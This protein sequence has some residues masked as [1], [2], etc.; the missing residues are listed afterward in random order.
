MA[1]K[2]SKEVRSNIMSKIRSKNTTPELK[3][4]EALKG[5]RL[6]YQPKMDGKPDFA[7][8]KKK[9]AVFVD[10]CF[11]HKCPKCYRPPK[12]NKKYWI[13]KIERNVERD[14]QIT[15]E[16]EELGWTAMRFWEHEVLESSQ[17]CAEQI[18]GKLNKLACSPVPEA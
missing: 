9:I 3:L 5:T 7:S 2:V 13:P 12:T 16:L 6:R 10:G 11:W 14:K 17:E 18:R 15:N 8:K 4:K 1:D